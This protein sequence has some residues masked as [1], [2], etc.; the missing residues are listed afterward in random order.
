M[1]PGWTDAVANLVNENV[2]HCLGSKPAALWIVNVNVDRLFGNAETTKLIYQYF[3]LCNYSVCPVPNL[4]YVQVILA[5]H[6]GE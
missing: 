2:L 6:L 3:V 5:V 4:G 1:A